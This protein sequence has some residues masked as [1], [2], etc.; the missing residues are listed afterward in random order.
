VLYAIRGL[1]EVY[2]LVE[3]G[4]QECDA[5]GKTRW[6]AGDHP[7]RRHAYLRKKPD[8]DGRLKA[9]IE[10]LMTYAPAPSK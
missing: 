7:T 5:A 10:E 2:E 1:G 4:Y 9:M 8:V 6:L 3:G